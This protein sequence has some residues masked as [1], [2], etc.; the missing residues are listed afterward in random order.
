MYLT[1]IRPG[2]G[3]GVTTVWIRIYPIHVRSLEKGM[4]LKFQTDFKMMWYELTRL[5]R[6][7][8]EDGIRGLSLHTVIDFLLDFYML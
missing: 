7:W 4:V 3:G 6:K 2:G 5:L 8:V 1:L